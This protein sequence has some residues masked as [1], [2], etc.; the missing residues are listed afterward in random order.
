[1][2]TAEFAFNNKV[3]TATKSSPFQINYR[4]EPRMGFDIRK[5]GKNEKAEEFAR[6]MKERHE[7]ARA[8][9][10]KSQEEMKRQADKSRKE[11]EEYR[12]GDKV[13]IN[14]KDFSMELMKRVMKKLTEKFIGPYVVR[15]IV[16]ENAVELELLASLRVHL[17]VNVRRLVKYREQVEGQKKIPPPPV[18]VA[19]EKEYE[20]EEIL[21][22]QERR[23]KIRYLVKWK[24]YT[25][26]EN[27]WEGLENLKNAREKIEEFEKGRFEEEIRRIR[28]KKGKETKLNPETEEFR[29]G[30][31]PGRY[32]AKL[33]YGWDDKKFDEEYLKKLEKNWNR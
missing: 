3:H 31:L 29:R 11:A 7:E 27:T 19:G 6:E 15:K 32:I 33:L 14:T 13:L 22:R 24:G 26:E 18:K 28:M 8:A 12:V 16:S 10:V 25:A 2:A 5:K 23:G 9:L 30:E 4:R 20:V 21:D 17:V 1:M